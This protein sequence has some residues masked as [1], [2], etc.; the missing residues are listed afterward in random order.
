MI[1][2]PKSF[3]S[4]AV[5]PSSVQ[6]NLR[7]ETEFW[8]LIRESVPGRAE[9]RQT[10]RHTVLPDVRPQEQPFHS[11]ETDLRIAKI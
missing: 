10:I 9:E 3:N 6:E 5:L 2:L 4:G 11:V 1:E 8:F 7:T